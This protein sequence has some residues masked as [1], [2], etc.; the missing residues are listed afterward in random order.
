M[1][2]VYYNWVF[3]NTTNFPQPVTFNDIR[4]DPIINN[5][6]NYEL[7]VIK[8]TIP[9]GLLPVIETF[10]TGATATSQMTGFS[11]TM[12]NSGG[13]A[14]Q[15]YLIYVPIDNT[16][17]TIIY[18]YNTL[19]DMVNV[20]FKNAATAIGATA[21]GEYPFM[22]FDSASQLFSIYYPTIYSTTNVKIWFNTNLANLFDAFPY[23]FYNQYAFSFAN[24]GEYALLPNNNQNNPNQTEIT[25]YN[26]IIQE[27]PSTIALYQPRSL[28]L[29]SGN[30]PTRPESIPIAGTS[31]STVSGGSN[32]NS[33][34]ILTDF[35]LPLANSIA[36][37]KPFVQYYQVG[38]YRY[39][40]LRTQGALYQFDVT[41]Y[42][43]DE[44]GNL[45]PL[46]INPQQTVNI[47]FMFK[48]KYC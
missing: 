23:Q 19:M 16:T 7:A 22:V 25:D 35:D 3:T 5:M 26:Q 46:F 9:T 14:S 8:F 4:T 34:V 11:L 44:V 45:F 37:I 38:P 40:D 28:R 21:G 20:A 43:V 10:P 6:E 18:S 32:N 15:Q 2:N 31:T 24:S 36:D 47:K 13:T 33:Q 12:V 41:I 48:N 1:S 39:I 30:V 29:V 17:D 27:Y 42:W